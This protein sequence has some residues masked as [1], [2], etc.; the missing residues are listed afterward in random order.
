[1]SAPRGSLRRNCSRPGAGSRSRRVPAGRRVRRQ[2]KPASARLPIPRIRA[3][4]PHRRRR[5]RGRAG[6]RE[7][8]TGG[9]RPAARAVAA[10]GRPSPPR[11]A[12]AGRR[13]G[14]GSKPGCR[15]RPRR[16]APTGRARKP[17][18]EPGC[19]PHPT[20]AS[21]APGV[22]R[23]SRVAGCPSSPPRHASGRPAPAHRRPLQA[24]PASAH[25]ARP[26][27]WPSW[28]RPG[29][30]ASP[31]AVRPARTPA[32]PGPGV[33]GRPGGVSVRRHTGRSVR[34]GCPRRAGRRSA[35]W[36]AS[37]GNPDCG[38]RCRTRLTSRSPAAP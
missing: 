6:V 31:A 28:R 38:R 13:A 35:R 5:S 32:L 24:R 19:R 18:R 23:W 10:T 21:P 14:H 3:R 4:F 30:R 29:R 36:L 8:R 7:D 9:A 12:A 27:W 37:A 34:H 33:A 22:P 26:A 25:R 1:M 2:R 20:A 15:P 17:R 16:R 11:P